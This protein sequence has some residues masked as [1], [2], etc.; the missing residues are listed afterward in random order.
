MGM[1]VGKKYNYIGVA[2]GELHINV[3]GDL[4][5]NYEVEFATKEIDLSGQGDFTTLPCWKVACPN[6]ALGFMVDSYEIKPELIDLSEG[7]YDSAIQYGKVMYSKDEGCLYFYDGSYSTA[8]K[9][10]EFKARL[11]SLNYIYALAEEEVHDIKSLISTNTTLKLNSD[12]MLEFIPYNVGGSGGEYPW[13]AHAIVT[14]NYLN[15]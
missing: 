13:I 7:S 4:L 6:G 2:K 12:K 5:S 8:D 3:K 10:T 14:V 15:I 11:A 9:L 1:S